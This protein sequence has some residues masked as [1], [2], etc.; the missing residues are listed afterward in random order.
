MGFL[1]ELIGAVGILEGAFRMPVAGFVVAL[2]VVFGSGP[3]GVRGE[4]VL[5][6]GFTMG[7][8]HGGLA[9]AGDRLARGPLM[10][11]KTSTIRGEAIGYRG[12]GGISPRLAES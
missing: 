3:M 2:F 1:G 12:R 5:F 6:R 8:V 9:S 11:P 10:A 4:F 7:F